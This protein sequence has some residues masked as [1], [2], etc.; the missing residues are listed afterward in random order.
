MGPATVPEIL[1]DLTWALGNNLF[2]WLGMEGT[3]NFWYEA[4][5]GTLRFEP[6]SARSG[7]FGVDLDGLMA[8]LVPNPVW[9]FQHTVWAKPGVF[10]ALRAARVF[11]PALDFSPVLY[12][13]VIRVVPES[14]RPYLL[15]GPRILANRG[16]GPSGWTRAGGTAQP[17]IPGSP[18]PVFPGGGLHADGPITTVTSPQAAHATELIPTG[19]LLTG[20]VTSGQVAAEMPGDAGGLAVGDHVLLTGGAVP[21]IADVAALPASG[22]ATRVVLTGAEALAS[23]AGS[24]VVRLRRLALQRKETESAVPSHTD[25]LDV[26]AA[27]GGYP[28]GAALRLSQSGA[29]V[30]TVLVT[31]LQAALVLAGPQPTGLGGPITV[32]SADEGGIPVTV[33]LTAPSTLTF[34]T[35]ATTPP[36]GQ[37]LA[38]RGGGGTNPVVA[39]V[40][41][42][43]AARQVTVDADLSA[44]TA[45]V[46]SRRVV[47]GVRMGVAATA[48]A[49]DLVLAYTPDD[50]GRAAGVRYVRLEPATGPVTVRRVA[51]VGFDALGV[52]P[53]LPGNAGAAYDVEVFGFSGTDRSGLALELVSGVTLSPLD[54]LTGAKTLAL[55]SLPGSPPTAGAT[56]L[57]GGAVTGTVAT[58][59]PFGNRPGT[60]WPTQVVLTRTGGGTPAPALITALRLTVALDRPLSLSPSGLQ[61]LKL[62]ST[63]L[64]YDADRIDQ[65]TVTVLPTVGRTATAAGTATQ[66]P[67]L[68][69]GELVAL[70][71]PGGPATTAAYRV[72]AVDGTTLSL[73]EGDPVPAGVAITATRLVPVDPGTGGSQVAINGATAGIDAAGNTQVIF[74]VWTLTD[75]PDSSAGAPTWIGIV[76]G[77]ACRPAAVLKTVTVTVVLGAPPASAGP[78]DILQPATAASGPAAWLADVSRTETGVQ[79][80]GFTGASTDTVVAVP[81]RE[82]SASVDGTLSSGTVLSPSE[83]EKLELDRFDALCEHELWHTVQSSMWG[84]ALGGF[85]PIGLLESVAAGLSSDVELPSYSAY[86]GGAISG[87][88][89]TI[90]DLAGVNIGRGDTLQVTQATSSSPIEITVT[91][92]G[93]TAGEFTVSRDM[94]IA[95]GAVSVRRKT[96]ASWVSTLDGALRILTFGG[97][98]NLTTVNLYEGLGFLIAHGIYWIERKGG[99]KASAY[100]ASVTENG[101]TLTLAN[102]A[103][104]VALRSAQRVFVAQGDTVQ[105]RTVA[106]AD[107]TSLQLQSPVQLSGNVQVSQYTTK[108]PGSTWDWH[109]YF[110]ATMPDASRPGALRLQ[111]VDGRTLSLAVRDQVTV[112]YD[113]TPTATR[114]GGGGDGGTTT[115]VTRPAA[116][117]GSKQTSVVAV[118]ADGTVEVADPPP[119]GADGIRVAR[120]D[121][122]DPMGNFDSALSTDMGLGHI[123]R[124][125]TDPY[126]QI[127]VATSGSRGSLADI[128]GR[129]GR[130]LFST[131][132]FMLPIGFW[133][134]DNAVRQLAGNPYDS[135]MEQGASE[136]SGDT[137]NAIGRLHPD[138]SG[139][140]VV[141]DVYRYW[142][143]DNGSQ[144][145]TGSFVLGNMG[146][147]PG[148]WLGGTST[149]SII[150]LLMPDVTAE[151]GASPGSAGAPPAPNL[152][153][154]A[155]V[156]S[157]DA[158]PHTMM[159]PP[160]T[161]PGAPP[162]LGGFAPQVRGWIPGSATLERT[163]GMYVAF[164]RPPVAGGKHRVTASDNEGYW[165]TA[166]HA[167]DDGSS[168]VL[169]GVSPAP[170][171]VTAAGQTIADGGTLTIIPTQRATITV[172]PDGN[173][174][175]ALLMQ[176]PTGGTVVHADGD[177]TVVGGQVAGTEAVEVVRR[178]ARAADG[179]LGDASLQLHGLHLPGG[180]DIPVGRFTVTLSTT[181]S[182]R[183]STD[184]DAAT[185]TE[186]RPGDEAFLLIQAAVLVPTRVDTSVTVGT[187]VPPPASGSAPASL[188]NTVLPTPPELATLLGPGVLIRTVAPADT[189]PEDQ[190]EITL[191]TLLG[192]A[193]TPIKLGTSVRVTPWFRLLAP[194]GATTWRVARGSTVT[195][196]ISDAVVAG[197]A[198]V[199]PPDGVTVTVGAGGVTLTVAATAAPGLRALTAVDAA[200]AAHTARRSILIV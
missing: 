88:T 9:T 102:D 132:A 28:A 129:V 62:G 101:S 109:D 22:G 23:A 6:I 176:R 122:G 95:D 180:L 156:A 168:S 77:A 106:L 83:P 47:A 87:T 186:L 40:V 113:T 21:V 97:L 182:L 98:L 31:G 42:T 37:F 169:Y 15:A 32:F 138:G 147:A 2:G 56:L 117:G 178:Y 68:A 19:A 200:A 34:P 45:P 72:T 69:V 71:W 4:V 149:P 111:Q 67:R 70:S 53:S 199:T 84:G 8:S 174:R 76:D 175:Y 162:G 181:L 90:A 27:A 38:I 154:T 10:E 39:V 36:I 145:S 141:G 93:A 190:S 155:G 52:S 159:V 136:R 165:L 44:L 3:L 194:A 29:V 61:A 85:L 121:V 86:L 166:R 78:I 170:V 127:Q 63:G 104:K 51:S 131:R 46:T 134:L 25:L 41:A 114:A 171:V 195:F 185:I 188:Q 160:A 133:F 193:A 26:H 152:G 91:G 82:T 125:V 105:T 55:W 198:T 173:R 58:F 43:P 50:P 140:K 100:P 92:V 99:Q 35:A 179:S 135:S 74:D 108:L 144:R 16:G 20:R 65:T 17:V 60:V 11:V 110:P 164:T 150:P 158:I 191:V 14:G 151:S 80:P 13:S 81:F 167:Q 5:T 161:V 177:T 124:W 128:L 126:G 66:M 143:T 24:T 139:P 57:T 89:L 118:D 197:T 112:T 54:A 59:P 123:T 49:A 119:I 146:D 187:P 103:G 18:V 96:P 163:A 116:V 153:A 183:A 157:G 130:T 48:P 148:I 79:A 120:I 33:T 94:A 172:T 196:G 142:L 30:G 184:P 75:L 12:A 189:P 137:Y 115:D 7:S 192:D 107:D 73:A 1:S 64:S